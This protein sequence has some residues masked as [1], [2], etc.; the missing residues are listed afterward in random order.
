MPVYNSEQWVGEA[1]DSVL[2]QT[3]RD[4]ELVICDN[5]STDTTPQI[6][7][8]H[9]ARDPRVRYYRN[10]ENLGISENYNRVFRRSNGTYFKWASSNDVCDERLV[11]RCVAILDTRSDVVLCYGHTALVGEH[12]HG[13][14]DYED[15]LDLPDASAC[16]R[17]EKVLRRLRLNNVMNGVIRA[18]ALRTTA[19]IGVY[20]SADLVLV[21]ELALH[22]KFVELPERMFYRRMTADTST[23]MSGTERARAYHDPKGHGR[24]LF[25]HWKLGFGYFGAAARAPLGARERV[26][27]YLR[28]FRDLIWSRR[29][30]AADIYDAL[31]SLFARAHNAA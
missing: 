3:Y 14:E 15:N 27:V 13:A 28:V 23:K 12:L 10:P 20:Y 11:E 8:A 9:A 22:G 25:Q 6:C 24:M 5:A 2:G 16:V 31:C 30:L 21:A 4:L 17:L 7:R 19:L 1:I 18:D 26:C 29:R